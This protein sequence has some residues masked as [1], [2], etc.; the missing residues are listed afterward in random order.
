MLPQNDVESYRHQGY[1]SGRRLLSAAEAE[2]FR[3]DCLRTCAEPLVLDDQNPYSLKRH[4]SNRVKPYLLFP[5]AAELVRHPR[6]L[7]LVEAVIGPDILVF[8]TTVWMKAAHS[9]NYV[10]WHQ[11]ATYFGLAPF[12]HVTAWVALTQSRPESG[13]VR[14]I[15]GSHHNGQLGHFDDHKDPLTMLS[16]GQKLTDAIRE[17]DAVDLVLE[18]G[19]VSLHHTLTVHSSRI[20]RSD[21]WRIGVGISYIPASVRHIGPTR[22]SATLARGTDRFNYFDHEAPPQ[23]ELDEAALAVHADSQS[24]YWKAASGIAEMRH[25]H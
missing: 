4:A 21:E 14:V 15:P 20:N 6:V 10:P 25:I 8:H 7:D 23:G 13:C 22:L 18:P 11:D 16:R 3:N 9:E 17:E 24:R 12:E 5:W 19:D 1:L 2:R